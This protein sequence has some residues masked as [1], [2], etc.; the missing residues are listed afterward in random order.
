MLMVA[1]VHIV[2]VLVWKDCWFLPFFWKF[3]APL[4]TMKASSEGRDV[5]RSV[6]VQGAPWI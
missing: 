4:G 3:H 1:I 6:L 2:V 5:F